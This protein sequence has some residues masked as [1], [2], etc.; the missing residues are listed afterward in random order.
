[1]FHDTITIVR[2][3]ITTD[4]YGSDSLDYVTGARTVV[5]RVSVQPRSSVE[6]SAD[7]RDMVTTGWRIYSRSGTDLDIQP[8]DRVEWA[9]RTLEVVGEVARWPHPTRPGAVHHVEV[10]VQKVSG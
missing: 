3:V 5:E 10:D 8:T 4:R 1:M 7:A 9:A 6:V 2:P